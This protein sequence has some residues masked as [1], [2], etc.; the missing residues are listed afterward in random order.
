MATVLARVEYSAVSRAEEEGKEKYVYMGRLN[1]FRCDGCEHEHLLDSDN[2]Q[3][4]RYP[5][6][7][8]PEDWFFVRQGR[9]EH[10]KVWIFC[11]SCCL[12]DYYILQAQ[13]RQE[14]EQEQKST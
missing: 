2:D 7:Q 6:T 11:S 12:I 13:V 3:L 9:Q 5:Y 8:F 14:Q 4:T 1:G 10:S